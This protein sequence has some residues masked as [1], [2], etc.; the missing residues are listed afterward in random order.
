VNAAIPD[1]LNSYCF[2]TVQSNGEAWQEC[3][4]DGFGLTGIGVSRNRPRALAFAL[5]DLARQVVRDADTWK[6]STE[7]PNERS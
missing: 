2:R 7:P 3:S 1:V 5:E 4:I 6:P